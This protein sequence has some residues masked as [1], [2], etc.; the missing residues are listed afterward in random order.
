M[1]I[2]LIVPL[3]DAGY[4][5]TFEGE[6]D[7]ID[8]TTLRVRGRLQD[9]VTDLQH[10]WVLRTPEY[11]VL[12]ASAQQHNGGTAHECAGYRDIRGVRIGRGFSKRILEAL[13]EDR[14]AQQHLLL[15]LEMAR[16]GQ[17]VYQFP[18]GF[19]E[20][21]APRAD[22]ASAEALLQWEKDRAYMA[23]LGES[24]HTYRNASAELFKTRPIT[25]TFGAELTRPAPGTRR[26][27]WRR[28]NLCIR[29]AGDGFEC[30]NHMEDSL[31]DIAVGFHLSRDG[32]V[33][34]PRSSG[35][36]LPYQGLCDDPH[37][38]MARLD[39]LRLTPQFIG[40]LAEHVGG[41]QGCTHL[42]DLSTD[43]LKLFRL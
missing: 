9:H 21:F 15:A 23:S 29:P 36:R 43:C 18:P 8:A 14:A 28:K 35:A 24:C 33:S 41:A 26:A 27:F 39:G 38:R 13:G 19:E 2:E 12:E 6:V 30:E 25:V 34:Q 22:V 40:Q 32:I 1:A 7:V 37:G 4:L 11:E 42:F 31:H 5:R 10:G 16:L 20:A 3:A 17:Q